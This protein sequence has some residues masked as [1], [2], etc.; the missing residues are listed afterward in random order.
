MRNTRLPLKRASLRPNAWWAFVNSSFGLWF[1]SAIF[2]SGVGSV[3]TYSRDQTAK[4]AAT[5]L[6]IQKLDSEISYRFQRI[7]AIFKNHEYYK[8]RIEMYRAMRN[9]QWLSGAVTQAEQYL[10]GLPIRAEFF[11]AP[12]LSPEIDRAEALAVQS[13]VFPDV[14]PHIL[15]NGSPEPYF[16]ALYAEYKH[17][18]L[19]ALIASLHDEAPQSEK[20]ELTTVLMNLTPF[21]PVLGDNDAAKHMLLFVI[22]DRWRKGI[23]TPCPEESDPLC[24]GQPI[25]LPE[26]SSRSSVDRYFLGNRPHWLAEI[27]E[28]GML[29]KD[30]K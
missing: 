21:P 29:L 30:R 12:G 4:A 9:E 28:N 17:Y 8:R 6:R 27:L 26:P 20:R 11:A 25:E 7:F 1:L 24:L 13:I 2:I 19:A 23:F 16:P 18:N 15:V 5:Q 22:R 3:Y 10:N 14:Q